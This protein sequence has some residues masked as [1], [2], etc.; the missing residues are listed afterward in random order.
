MLSKENI[1]SQIQLLL[2]SFSLITLTLKESI[3]SIALSLL[4]IYSLFYYI[5]C[6]KAL[7]FH[8]FYP[9][10]ILFSILALNLLLFVP[11][12]QQDKWK[13]L[14]RFIPF[15]I[16]PLSFSAMKISEKN[17]TYTQLIFIIW[18]C[19]NALYS[20]TI[21]LNR[22]FSNGE[23]L[24]L[25]FRKDYSYME[26]SHTIGLDSTYYAYFVLLAIIISLQKLIKENK[27]IN[28][29]LYITLI[30]YLSFFIIH[31]S[32]R[33][34]IIALLGVIL[35]YIFYYFFLRKKMILGFICILIT[36]IFISTILYNVRATR[37]RF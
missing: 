3:N 23:S 25:I 7:S 27:K 10:L 30:S 26:L 33:M 29:I 4:F 37:Y 5:K 18:I 13:Y 9:F 22:L 36:S 17:I 19:I 14:L 16:I 31:L 34:M 32:S 2:L 12:D 35:Y 1:T 11:L 21:I 28:R 15:L 8:H 6:R 24:Y 20:H